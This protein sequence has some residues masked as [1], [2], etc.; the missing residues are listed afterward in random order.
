MKIESFYPDEGGKLCCA[1]VELGTSP[2]WFL[3]TNAVC[4]VC[5]VS[6]NPKAVLNVGD[7]Q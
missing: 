2:L 7:T 5:T 6:S 4:C 1:I 3:K